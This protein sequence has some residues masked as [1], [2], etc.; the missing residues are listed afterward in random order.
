MLLFETVSCITFLW[1]CGRQNLPFDF[2]KSPVCRSE[3]LLYCRSGFFHSVQDFQAVPGD[4]SLFRCPN[5]DT[6]CLSITAYSTYCLAA[7]FER[8]HR[9][10]LNLRI[11][12]K[13][14]SCIFLEDQRGNHPSCQS[15]QRLF[16]FAHTPLQHKD[17]IKKVKNN[18]WKVIFYWFESNWMFCLSSSFLKQTET[19]MRRGGWSSFS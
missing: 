9:E 17:R 11:P 1:I 13:W 3:I 14:A 2:I 16:H 12:D 5:R 15:K 18:I 4:I 10:S 6:V 19:E 7:L 8:Q